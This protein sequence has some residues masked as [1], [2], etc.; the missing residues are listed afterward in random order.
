MAYILYRQM[1]VNLPYKLPGGFVVSKSREVNI[2]IIRNYLRI[3]TKEQVLVE[4]LMYYMEN[5]N[6]GL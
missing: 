6:D 3:K 5:L 4:I 1:M 2:K